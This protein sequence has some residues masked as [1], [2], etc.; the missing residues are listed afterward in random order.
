MKVVS[1]AKISRILSPTSPKMASMSSFEARPSCTLL[2]MA[3]SAFLCS[4]SLSR[5]CVSSKRRAFSR[6]TLKL[7]ASVSSRRTSESVNAFS[8]RTS[9]NWINPRACSPTI[10]GTSSVDFGL[11]TSPTS[12]Y[13]PY[14]AATSSVTSLMSSV[15]PV[16]ITW[17]PKPRSPRGSAGTSH[18]FPSQNA[19]GYCTRP[20]RGS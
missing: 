8:R 19:Y 1:A 4:V 6:A 14:R 2:M 9:L 7:P 20:A 18:L 3:S 11:A 12:M 15:S 13:D 5:R 10:N 16:R 17:G